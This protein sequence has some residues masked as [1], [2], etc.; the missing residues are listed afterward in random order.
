MTSEVKHDVP[1]TFSVFLCC[2]LH[3]V[4]TYLVNPETCPAV[5][6]PIEIRGNGGT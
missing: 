1:R 6:A 3:R 4:V 5:S 2:P